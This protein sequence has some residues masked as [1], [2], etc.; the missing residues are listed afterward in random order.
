MGR[1]LAGA[2][3]AVSDSDS[4]GVDEGG[5]LTKALVVVVLE[6]RHERSKVR[7]LDAEA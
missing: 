5:E 6:M 4:L 7:G 1:T 3:Y 2:E